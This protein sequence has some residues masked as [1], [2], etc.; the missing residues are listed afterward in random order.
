ME[1][2]IEKCQRATIATTG[3]AI[4]TS[5]SCLLF[6]KSCFFCFRRCSR[7]GCFLFAFGLGALCLSVFVLG[8]FSL[9]FFGLSAFGLVAFS[10]G[11]F[12]LTVFGLGAFRVIFDW[13]AI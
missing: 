9:G 5:N 12:G 1:H 11:A 3:T 6:W 13:M 10:L 7:L 2:V 8:V 4:R